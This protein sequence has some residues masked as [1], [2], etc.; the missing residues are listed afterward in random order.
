[1]VLISLVFALLAFL[2][3]STTAFNASFS[4]L[5]RNYIFGSGALMLIFIPII[6]G[7]IGIIFGALSAVLYNF[8]AGRIG[9]VKIYIRE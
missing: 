7:I 6:Y 8:I 1:M 2:I 3:I 5:R 9:G 4:S